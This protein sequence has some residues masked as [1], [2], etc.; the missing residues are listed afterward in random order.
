MATAKERPTGTRKEWKAAGRKMLK[1]HYI[2][3]VLICVLGIYFSGE[4][5]Y[6][7]S[8]AENLNAVITKQ[9]IPLGGITFK[10]DAEDTTRGKVLQDIVNEDVDAGEAK[11]EEQLQEYKDQGVKREIQGRQAGIFAGIANNFSSGHMY[12]QIYRSLD[13]VF[14]SKSVIALLFMLWNL[15]FAVFVWVFLKNMYRGAM[16]RV[17]L[18]ARIYP[19]VPAGHLLHFKLVKCWKR[20]SMTLSLQAIYQALW[21][22]TII[23]GIIKHY[24]YMLVP[25]IVAENPYIKPREAIKLSRRMMD[26]YKWE[27]CKFELSFLGWH[28]LSA[29]TFGFVDALWGIPYEVCA[30]TEYYAQRRAM[31]IEDGIEG[32]EQLNDKYLYELDDEQHLRK[33]YADIEEQKHFIDTHRI[34]L[35]GA[36][37]FFAKNLGLWIGSTESKKQY[38]EVDNVRQQIVEDRAVIKHKVYPQRLNPRWFEDNKRVVK[39]TRYLR[40]YTIW[41]IIMV[42]FV[43]S[44]CGW[45]YE[46]GIHLFQDGVFVNRG[47]FHGPWLPIYGGGVAMIM[48]CLARFRAKIYQ[49]VVAIVVLCGIVEYFTSYFIEMTSGLRYWDYTGYFLNLNGRICGEGLTVFAI[50]GAAA[51]YLLVPVLDTMLSKINVKILAPI[52]IGLVVIFVADIIYSHYVPNTGDGITDYDSYKQV[53]GRTTVHLRADDLPAQLADSGT[54]VQADRIMV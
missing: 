20:A 10:L 32:V 47:A 50:G 51:V 45:C 24:S 18:E 28:L 15:F 52:C 31:A 2:L 42:F 29:V 49:E 22:I 43:F 8:Q 36:K 4:F 30:T 1:G 41:S 38:D 27:A 34:E 40:S 33:V 46:V 14:H 44:F 9:E 7:Q 6:I 35:Y 12:I 54:G 39:S 48:L 19:E 25:Y 5:G 11:A 21:D 53:E 16:R 26:G 3:I 13:S 37:L 17:L 23:G